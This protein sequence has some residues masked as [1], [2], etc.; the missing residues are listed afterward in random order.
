MGQRW[1]RKSALTAL[2]LT[3]LPALTGAWAQSVPVPAGGIL[4]T[5]EENPPYNFTESG[6]GRFRGI[7]G[8]LIPI[9]MERAGLPYRIEILPWSRAFRTAQVKK[10]VCV[11]STTVTSDRIKHFEWV[12][13]VAE[14][15]YALFAWSDWPGQV[16]TQ[17]DLR[18]L[19]VVVQAGGPEKPIL[20]SLD[21]QIVETQLTNLHRMLQAGRADLI[22]TGIVSG[23]WLMKYTGLNMKMVIQLSTTEL[24]LACNPGTDPAK[25]AAM[26]SALTS[27]REDGTVDRVYDAYR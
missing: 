2:L 21:M 14:G 4:L 10:D 16:Q 25:L 26:R 18:G 24:G 17:E 20:K 19:R 11:F 3:I 6:S 15:G 5:S 23:R 22:A 9:L 1:R 27:L 13:P 7:V 12:K 8:D